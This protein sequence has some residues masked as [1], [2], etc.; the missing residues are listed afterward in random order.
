MKAALAATVLLAQGRV[1]AGAQAPPLVSPATLR[2]WV[3]E[4]VPLL[5]ACLD[6]P[7]RLQPLLSPAHEQP[8]QKPEH[9]RGRG[10]PSFTLGRAPLESWRS[11]A[12]SGSSQCASLMAN[13]SRPH[14]PAA[15]LLGNLRR[16]ASPW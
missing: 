1:V 10:E 5:A 6:D 14:S 12:S 16:C 8:E 15:A 2:V 4:A 11:V 7:N 9:E 3:E 13:A